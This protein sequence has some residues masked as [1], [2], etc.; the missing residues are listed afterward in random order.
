V[1]KV[2]IALDA[3]AKEEK[4]ESAYDRE[5]SE[6]CV[7]SSPLG[8]DRFHRLYWVFT[9]SQNDEQRLFVQS[10]A[11]LAGFKRIEVKAE[12]GV[13]E[14]EIIQASQVCICC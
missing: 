5:L 6:L 3:K 11:T 2:Q 12:G 7:R 9:H 14:G 13:R 8:T 10:D 1:Y 4:V